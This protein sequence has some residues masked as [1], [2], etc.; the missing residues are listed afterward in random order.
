MT[1][2]HLHSSNAPIANFFFDLA[3]RSSVAALHVCALY[4]QTDSTS[5]KILADNG[6]KLIDTKQ[7]NWAESLEL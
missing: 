6:S 7:V 5:S 4:F 1:L 3:Y 2:A